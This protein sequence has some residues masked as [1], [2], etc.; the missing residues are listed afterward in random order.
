[1]IKKLNEISEVFEQRLLTNN[2][3]GYAVTLDLEKLNET[4]TTEA[5]FAV[6]DINTGVISAQLRLNGEPVVLAEDTLVYANIETPAIDFAFSEYLYQTCEVLDGNLGIVLLR[7]KTQAMKNEGIHRLEYV[8]QPSDQEKLISPKIK[9]EVFESLDSHQSEPAEDEIGVA[10]ALISE[11]AGT[12]VTIQTQ[13][14]IRV[15][16]ETARIENDKLR[17]Q[18]LQETMEIYRT[19]VVISTEEIDTIIANALK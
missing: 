1:M 6:G 10:T 18:K 15:A 12:N 17:E 13:E 14:E 8:I 5:R 2:I 16:N 19:Q 11:V 4:L 9:Y 7:F 3:R